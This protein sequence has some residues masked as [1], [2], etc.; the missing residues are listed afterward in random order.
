MGIKK[1]QLEIKQHNL[2]NKWLKKKHRIPNKHKKKRNN[3]KIIAKS[4]EEYNSELHDVRWY[5][6]RKE[7][8]MLDDFK[9]RI[10]GSEEKLVVHHK[11][12]I[13][14][15]KAWEYPN[16]LLITLCDECHAKFHGF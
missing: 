8:F 5:I 10:C 15:K 1:T 11:E 6:K 12:Y 9:C 16:E 2:I 13:E 4:K 7:I 14:G 3:I